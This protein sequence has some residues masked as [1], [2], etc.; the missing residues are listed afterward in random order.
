MITVLIEQDG[1]EHRVT[2]A[3]HAGYAEKGQDIVCA[4]VSSLFVA[5]CEAADREGALRDLLTEPDAKR[6]YI[7]RTKPAGHYLTMFRTGILAM[8]REYPEYVRLE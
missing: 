6:A 3:G 1:L 5:L 8:Q 4:G 7:Y 2:V